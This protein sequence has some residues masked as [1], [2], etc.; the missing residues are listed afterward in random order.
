VAAGVRELPA[1]A[2]W[3]H[4]VAHEGFEVLFPR[5]DADGY[6]FE[7][8]VAGIEEGIPWG[9]RYEIRVDGSWATR[10]ARLRSRSAEGEHELR[11]EGDGAGSWTLDGR[12][13]PEL[14]GLVDVDLEGSAFTNALPVKRLRR[15]V[16]EGF[17]AP[18]VYVRAPD[19]RVERL[20]QHYARLPDDGDAMR[21]DYASPAFGFRAVLLYDASGLVLDYPGIAVRA[22]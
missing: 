13:A 5:R 11:L 16:G 2:A 10:A 7:G 12:P 8:R 18:A 14:D 15:G 9:F 3:R 6:V 4:V 19:L 22:A 1:V 17:E 20:E 21:F